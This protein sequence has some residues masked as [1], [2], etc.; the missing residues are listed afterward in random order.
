[1]NRIY[2]LLAAF[3]FLMLGTNSAFAQT[4]DVR[5]I[6]VTVTEQS[7][8]KV[9]VDSKE[10]DVDGS[11]DLL[12]LLEQQG[13][14]DGIDVGEPGEK[15]EIV[16][17]KTTADQPNKQWRIQ[18]GGNEAGELQERLYVWQEK[19]AKEAEEAADYPMMGVYCDQTYNTPAD[20]N[21]DTDQPKGVRITSV[22][23]GNRC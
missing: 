8:G 11:Q 3:G 5:K 17:K 21:Q 14:L 1:M 15:L 23:A 13:V 12:E 19:R 20:A 22:M 4:D 9:Q 7:E 18:L 2:L 6:T 16:I 10:L